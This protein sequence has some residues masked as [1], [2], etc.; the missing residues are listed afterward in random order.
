M[1]IDYTLE[2]SAPRELVWRAFDNPSNLQKW[3]PSLISFDAVS[4]MPGQ[5]GAR[6]QLTYREGGHEIVLIE[7]VTLRREPEEF[8]GTYESDHGVNILSNRFAETGTGL[9]RWDVLTEM[10]LKG[11]AKFMA[12]MVRGMVE[13]RVRADCERFKTLL[14]AGELAT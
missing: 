12:P 6:S 8:A 10:Q 14:E 13:K 7:T 5:V 4:G 1:K 11:M 2:L 3:Q 9:T